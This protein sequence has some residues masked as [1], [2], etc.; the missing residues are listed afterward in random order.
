AAGPLPAGPGFEAAQGLSDTLRVLDEGE[1]DMAVAVLAE[2]DARGHRHLA[3]LDQQLGELERAHA[4][5][6]LRD[7]GPHEHGALG[8]GHAPADL[9]QAVDQHVAALAVQLHDVAHA[10]LLA[11]E[12][13]DRRDLDGLEPPES[14]EG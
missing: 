1:P 6:G 13:D 14:G 9:V 2:A 12:R 8:L 5:E 3:L 7:R 10:L 4:T 11:L